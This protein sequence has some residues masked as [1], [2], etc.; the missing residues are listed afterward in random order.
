MATSPLANLRCD[1][2]MTIPPS[3]ANTNRPCP[4]CGKTPDPH[5]HPFCSSRCADVDLHRWLGEN[6]RVQGEDGDAAIPE[7]G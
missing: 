5:F 4:I 6:Y 7:D 3:P 2:A 1:P